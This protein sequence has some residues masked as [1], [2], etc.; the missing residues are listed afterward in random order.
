MG[1]LGAFFDTVYYL[2][3]FLLIFLVEYFAALGTEGK[4][5]VFVEARPDTR[6]M[7]S[8]NEATHGCICT[9]HIRHLPQTFCGIA[10]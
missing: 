3:T 4:R 7:I 5:P 8:M 9:V 6:I 1:T 2:D 10:K